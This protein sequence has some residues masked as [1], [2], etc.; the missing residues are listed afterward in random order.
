M[1][2]WPVFVPA[3]GWSLFCKC[4]KRNAGDDE[5]RTRDLRR[6]RHDFFGNGLKLGGTD[7]Y[8]NRA[9]EPQVTFIGPGMDQEMDSA[10]ERQKPRPSSYSEARP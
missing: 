7:G 2:S 10:A 4:P 5:T 1:S 3:Q 9:L 6:G 8:Q